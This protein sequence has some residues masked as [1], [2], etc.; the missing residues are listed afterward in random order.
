MSNI[1]AGTGANNVIPGEMIIDFNFRFS[2]ASTAEGLK[3]ACTP[4]STSTAST[5]T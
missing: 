3:R 1:H 2:T 4:S 5:T